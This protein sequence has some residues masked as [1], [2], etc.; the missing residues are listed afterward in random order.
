ME[1]FRTLKRGDHF[2]EIGVIYGCKRTASVISQGYC[3]YAQLPI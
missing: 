1:N 3:T 2:G